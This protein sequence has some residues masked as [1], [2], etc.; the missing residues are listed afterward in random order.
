LMQG[1]FRMALPELRLAHK[2]GRDNPGLA[3]GVEQWLRHCE[4]L[5]EL[6]EQLPGIL[7]GKPPS[8]GPAVR[9]EL[10]R[11]CYFKRLHRAA[12]RFYKEALGL[13]PKLADDPSAS[14]R[15][16]A[17]CAAALAG[18]GRG[19]DAAKLDAEKY[20]SLRRHALDWLRADLTAWGRLL[21]KEPALV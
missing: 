3:S 20:A 1:E 9:L 6:D 15:H 13:D 8:P 10:A 7:A 4:R 16:D 18:C 12:A 17:A 21:D 2:L 14:Y 11:L 5:I 19:Q